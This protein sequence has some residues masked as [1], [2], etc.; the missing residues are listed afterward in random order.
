MKLR[1]VMVGAFAYAL[2]LSA[3]HA[4]PVDWTT[5]SA[6]FST[7]NAGGSA[8]GV[9][10]SNSVSY[11]GELQALLFGAP[12]WGPSSTFS[13]GAV[14]NA[15]QSSDGIL[16]LLGGTGST[17]TITFGT[18]VSNPV[19]AIWSLGL[20]DVPLS[21]VFDQAFTI[22]SGGPSA[23]H[24]GSTVTAFGLILNGT[25]GNGTI[26]FQGTFSQISWTNPNAEVYNDGQSQ[27]RFGFTVGDA[28][29][30]ETPLPAALPLFAG[31]LGLIGLLARRRKQ[32]HAAALS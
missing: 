24:G 26:M 1:G 32:R 12:S 9:I 19:M 22:E 8:A 31:G 27:G 21:F 7:G 3:I 18:P 4:S 13:G 14:G 16:L 10:G 30:A 20:T 28:S 5:W 11:S 29:V 17:N 6:T 23:E 2:S 25:E 15:P